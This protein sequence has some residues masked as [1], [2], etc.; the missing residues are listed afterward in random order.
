MHIG[1]TSKAII[2]SSLAG[3]VVFSLAY[4]GLFKLNLLIY[5]PVEHPVM[6]VVRIL[7][8]A[9]LAF[10]A[11]IWVLYIIEKKYGKFFGKQKNTKK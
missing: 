7:I 2:V 11:G 9:T 10:I 6:P 1:N 3:L 5:G 8:A 4:I